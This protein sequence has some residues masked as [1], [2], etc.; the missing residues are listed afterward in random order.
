MTNLSQTFLQIQSIFIVSNLKQIIFL[1]SRPWSR[2]KKL[3]TFKSS[4]KTFTQNTKAISKY[5]HHRHQLIG[6][7]RNPCV[8]VIFQG[9][10]FHSHNTPTLLLTLALRYMPLGVFQTVIKNKYLPHRIKVKNLSEKTFKHRV[11]PGESRY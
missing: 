8:V 3:L 1:L 2:E 7:K 4:S 6:T 5:W 9:P 11:K 10:I